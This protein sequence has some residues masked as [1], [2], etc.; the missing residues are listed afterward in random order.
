MPFQN[1]TIT[2]DALHCNQ[3]T[4]S[5]IQDSKNEY[6]IAVKRI[7]KIYIQL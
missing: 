2:L 7:K 6:L 3:K 1:Q 5:A 4:I